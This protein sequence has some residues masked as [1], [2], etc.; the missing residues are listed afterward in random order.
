MGKKQTIDDRFKY[1]GTVSFTAT[2][3]TNEFID[4]LKQGKIMSSRCL[5]CGLVFFPPRADCHHCLSSN[6][7]WVE[8]NGT[9]KL[10]TFSKLTFAPI[11]FEE[12][13]PYCIALLDYDAFKIFGRIGPNVAEDDI[14]IGT[15]M[16]TVV[17]TMPN[18]QMNYV[19]EVAS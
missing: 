17:N 10:V 19:F 6:M 4:F 9:G 3:K 2:T 12:D 7:E 8:V 16:K 5:D 13:V 1:F 11:G 15:K 14:R 18:G